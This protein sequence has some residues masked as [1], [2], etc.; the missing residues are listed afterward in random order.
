MRTTLN[1]PNNL[2]INQL[3]NINHAHREKLLTYY[4]QTT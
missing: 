3:I 2:P 4:R 1:K